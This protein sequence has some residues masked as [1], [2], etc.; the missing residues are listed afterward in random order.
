M[1]GFTVQRRLLA[2]AKLLALGNIKQGHRRPRAARARHPRLPVG[3]KRIL[4]SNTYYPALAADHVDLVTDPIAKVTGSAV[5]T[6]DGAERPID[7]LVVATGFHTTEQPIA[8]HI[9]GRD[10]ALAGR[11]R[12]ASAGW[13]AYKGT[14]VH[15]FPN[16]FQIVGANTGL[17]HSSD[18]VHDRVAARLRRGRDP[19]DAGQPRYGAVE[20]RRTRR[21]PGTA[22][23]SAA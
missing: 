14:T 17:G 23:S 18:G 20:P 10:G 22:T 2:P 3:C 9:V 4:I 5:V 13:Q 21:T 8:Q 19:H 11:G 16:L 7:V 15:G 1:P 6:A 12:G